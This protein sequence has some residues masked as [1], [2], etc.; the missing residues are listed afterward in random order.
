MKRQIFIR[1]SFV[2][3]IA[4]SLFIGKYSNN[5]IPI[6]LNTYQTVFNK[7]KISI[8]N[9]EIEL[10]ENWIIAKSDKTKKQVIVSNVPNM[11]DQNFSQCFI[12]IKSIDIHDRDK[13]KNIIKISEPIH[14]FYCSYDDFKYTAR[15]LGNEKNGSTL[16]LFAKDCNL[17]DFYDFV[18]GLEG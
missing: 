3:F 12:S 6:F 1:F 14:N 5:I 13:Y 15:C 7:K 2:L 18:R 9:F 11:F 17:N 4:L 8:Y 10:P 16:F